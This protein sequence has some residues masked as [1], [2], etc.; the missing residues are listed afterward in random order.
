M[1]LQ[2]LKLEKPYQAKPKQE[3]KTRRD[4]K[5]EQKQK[6]LKR[7]RERDLAFLQREELKQLK[8]KAEEREAN[9]RRKAKVQSEREDAIIKLFRFENPELSQQEFA[10][11]VKKIYGIDIGAEDYLSDVELKEAI[12]Q[13]NKR[14]EQSQKPIVDIDKEVERRVKEEQKRMQEEE[15]QA[16]RA[17][18]ER[19]RAE[20]VSRRK[21]QA[22]K[23]DF[24]TKNL[25]AIQM[26]QSKLSNNK[27]N[28]EE[29]KL[30]K[31]KYLRT[32]KRPRKQTLE[33]FDTK[34]QTLQDNI[35]AIEEI[36]NILRYNDTVA[37]RS[38][39][40]KADLRLIPEELQQEFNIN[41]IGRIEIVRKQQQ[42]QPL[43][44][45]LQR[46]IGEMEAQQQQAD[47]E[48]QDQEAQDQ[49]D[50]ADQER[51]Q[52][53]A[54]LGIQQAIEQPPEVVVNQDADQNLQDLSANGFKKL[55][56][57]GKLTKDKLKRYA[58]HPSHIKET[59]N[60]YK[61]NSKGI[62]HAKMLLENI[63]KHA[64]QIILF[65][66]LNKTRNRVHKI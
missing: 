47:Q 21:Y 41:E 58:I 4:F 63:P 30:A 6:E 65:S 26:F 10:K 45:E 51:A 28:I 24:I 42:Q 43:Q 31:E 64:K 16:K 23:E 60:G 52:D 7:I 8:Q 66:L 55:D 5:S 38:D 33:N 17:N 14:R 34:I 48:A 25:K 20:T 13:L 54:D 56:K 49:A 2:K 32:K 29:T 12:R 19:K 27:L 9:I 59:R 46:Q 3:K 22:E 37:R 40:K 1:Y 36:L 57:G 44:Q 18:L 62:K 35:P 61:L 15:A 11:Q 39:S 53:L 50:Q